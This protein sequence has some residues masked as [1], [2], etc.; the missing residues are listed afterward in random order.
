MFIVTA[1]AGERSGCLVG[2]AS[3]ASITPPR[4]AVLISKANHTCRV[5]AEADALAVHFLSQENL[6]LATLFGEETGDRVDKFSRC[7][8]STGPLGTTVLP[9]AMGWVAGRILER[10][11]AGD[12]VIH[13]IDTEAS[14]IHAAGR[15]LQFQQVRDLQP[16][17]PA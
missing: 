9:D 8:W 6:D 12:H 15:P 14:H 1:T 4:F 10:F 7:R 5:A 3:Q 11:D 13:L 16:G 17:H 2:F